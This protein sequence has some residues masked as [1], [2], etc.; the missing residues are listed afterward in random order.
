MDLPFLGSETLG[1]A[2]KVSIPSSLPE[3]FCTFVSMRFPRFGAASDRE[4]PSPIFFFFWT[5]K[6]IQWFNGEQ[7]PGLLVVI[8][9]WCTPAFSKVYLEITLH[10]HLFL[11]NL[12]CANF[13]LELL[14]LQ[15]REARNYVLW[16]S[17]PNDGCAC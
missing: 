8:P 14:N 16:T 9:I 2:E 17:S 6:E 5:Q 3:W 4:H 12:L 10:E 1:R 11:K 15:E 13:T 7:F